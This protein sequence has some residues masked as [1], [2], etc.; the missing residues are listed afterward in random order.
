LALAVEEGWRAF[1]HRRWGVSPENPPSRWSGLLAA[2][3]VDGGTLAEIGLLI[4]DLQ[5]LRSA[6][7]LSSTDTLRSDALERSR[8]ILRRL[9]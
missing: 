4:E 6:P 9:A 2:H 8:R 1:L 3:G 7:Q 5:Y